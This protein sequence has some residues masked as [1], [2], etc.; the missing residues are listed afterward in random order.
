L[1]GAHPVPTRPGLRELWARDE[2]AI[3]LM[4]TL[5][6]SLS[7]EL[8]AAAGYD[9]VCVDT[10]H[11]LIGY[12]QMVGMLQAL[13]RRVPT[14]V[15]VPWNEP[16]AIM[17]ALDAGADG[18][19][20]PM[21]NTAAQA[22]AATGAVRY[23]PAGYRS[24]GPIRAALAVADFGPQTENARLVCAVMIETEEAV[25]NIDEILAVPGVDVAFVGPSDLALSLRGGFEGGLDAPRAVELISAVRTSCARHE[26]IPGIAVQGP[27]RARR[28]RAEGFRMLTIHSDAALLA[29]AAR[30]LLM[31]TAPVA[32]GQ[33]RLSFETGPHSKEVKGQ[34]KGERGVTWT[35]DGAG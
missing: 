17:R 24:Y 33:E 31:A 32:A 20:V 8:V 15:R 29:V 5:S 18:V 4:C 6:S 2:A 27:E 12:E 11:G 10:Q 19:V 14:L 13:G 35:E 16:A 1:T 23:P 21:V 25:A 3:G 26:V 28:W 22:R 30:E 9:W 7:V 34:P